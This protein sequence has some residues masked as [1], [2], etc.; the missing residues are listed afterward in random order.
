MDPHCMKTFE[1]IVSDTFKI[2]TETVS[3]ELA[4][5]D[6]AEW[7]SMNYLLFI[8]ELEKEFNISFTMDEVLNAKNLGDIRK[9][10]DVRG[11]R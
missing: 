2:P 7:D 4:G 1:Q 9:I 5:K 10:I 11:K 6:I 8:A 3:D